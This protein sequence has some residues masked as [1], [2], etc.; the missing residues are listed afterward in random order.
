MTESR[1]GCG[2]GFIGCSRTSSNV[3]HLLFLLFVYKMMNI[4][5]NFPTL[6]GEMMGDIVR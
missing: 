2:I 3:V 5:L 6:T 4:Q 1:L